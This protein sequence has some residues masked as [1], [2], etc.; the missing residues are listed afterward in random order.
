MNNK[1]VAGYFLYYNSNRCQLSI[2]VWN[3]LKQIPQLFNVFIKYDVTDRNVKIPP[4]IHVTPSIIVPTS[5]GKSV[6]Y[7]GP[8]VI[9]WIADTQ[10]QMS[11]Q[12]VQQPMQ[13]GDK[14]AD[15]PDMKQGAP[16]GQ[17][18]PESNI[19]DPFPGFSNDP[20]FTSYVDYS[21]DWDPKVLHDSSLDKK[22][23]VGV[24][25]Y[26]N[27]N[28]GIS[29]PPPMPTSRGG[30]PPQ[31]SFP[32]PMETASKNKG[33]EMNMKLKEYESFRDMDIPT[34]IKREGAAEAPRKEFNAR[35]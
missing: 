12:P 32:A 7:D 23:G 15:R 14:V 2:D 17:Q 11:R 31:G 10:K 3:R 28:P 9:Q 30:P 27:Q 21:A 1:G 29:R 5:N 24:Y 6:V 26:L 33:D 8:S 20:G 4:Y 35:N 19:S 13:Q 22:V 18:P 25:E 34:G 16:Q